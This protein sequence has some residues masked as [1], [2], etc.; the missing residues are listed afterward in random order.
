MPRPVEHLIRKGSVLVAP[1]LFMIALVLAGCDGAT[2]TGP[3][4]PV[5]G[6]TPCV[7]GELTLADGPCQPAGLPPDMPCLPGELLREDGKCQPAGL[8]PDM[9]CPPGE[10]LLDNGTC[11]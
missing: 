3:P 11:Q 6:P 5:A 2:A 10:L 1:W 4:A 9:P 7:P 8:P